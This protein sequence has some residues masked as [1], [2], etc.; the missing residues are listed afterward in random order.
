MNLKQL[1]YITTI[2]ETQNISKAADLLFI[3][4]P[5][6]N[7]YLTSLE[8]ELGFPLFKRIRKKLIPTEA[9]AVYIRS[10]KE[11]LE[12]KKQTYKVLDE[13][14]NC[15]TGCLNL[16]I[17]RV[18]GAAMFNRI[19]PVFH[20]KY[21]YFTVNL[22][23]GNVNKLEE[24]VAEGKIDFAVIGQCSIRSQLEHISFAPCEVV[25]ALPLNHPLANLA[26]PP[27]Q[28]YASLDLKLLKNDAFILMSKD[29]KLRS[30]AESHFIK[31]GF[32]PKIMLETSL[33]STAYEMVRQGVGPSI[34]ME[35][36][37]KDKQSAACFS[38]E[39]KEYWSQSI[40]FRKGMIFTKAE[41]YFIEL[42]KEYFEDL[43]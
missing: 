15:E 22:V 16:G 27:N 4:R 12:I 3:S 33:S 28:P 5:A 34:L 11:I 14:S 9:G 29:T 26:A 13:L 42:A 32:L 6:L 38:L 30:I 24:Y 31:A 8:R 7:H 10:A 36:S 41:S 25:T 2:A 40:A 1:T 43:I 35:T 19:F 20:E 39:P 23:E 18:I 37:I 21:P 17:T